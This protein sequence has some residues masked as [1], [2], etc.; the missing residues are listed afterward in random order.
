MAFAFLCT[1]GLGAFIRVQTKGTLALSAAFGSTI[2]KQWAD[3]FV[4]WDC[5]NK[6]PQ[7]GWGR[8]LNNRHVCLDSSGGWEAQA[9]VS[10]GV[11]C[12][13]AFLVPVSKCPLLT[14]TP[15]RRDQDPSPR[16]HS[17]SS[18]LYR[19]IFKYSHFLGSWRVGLQPMRFGGGQNSPHHNIY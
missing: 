7:I 8:S 18:P 4:C 10:A 12:A 19:P 9:T 3:A 1:I 14:R 5:R 6:T 17:P 11:V 15:A 2:N 16:P 13:W